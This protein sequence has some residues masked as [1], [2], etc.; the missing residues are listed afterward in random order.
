M[1]TLQA[2]VAHVVIS[3]SNILTNLAARCVHE[4]VN[5]LKLTELTVTWANTSELPFSSVQD[6]DTF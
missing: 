6:V 4:T 2:I 1:V 5:R 3:I